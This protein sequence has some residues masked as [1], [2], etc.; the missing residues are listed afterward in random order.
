MNGG[1]DKIDICFM[2]PGFFCLNFIMSTIDDDVWFVAGAQLKRSLWTRQI[3]LKH[4]SILSTLGLVS[5][6]IFRS[7]D[8]D[9]GDDKISC[10]SFTL[11]FGGNVLCA[12]GGTSWLCM[13]L[14]V[15]THLS[16]MLITTILHWQ[17]IWLIP[18]RGWKIHFVFGGFG[19]A[20]FFF[21]NHGGFKKMTVLMVAGVYT[22][23]IPIAC[24]TFVCFFCVS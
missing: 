2:N 16:S 5:R 15:T 22:K 1:S 12:I 13:P 23:T 18:A 21:W 20:P 10:W 4:G 9:F 8:V 14:C 3:L 7:K 6:P 11:D 19:A 17:G 24:S